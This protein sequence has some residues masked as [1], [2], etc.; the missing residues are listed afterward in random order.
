MNDLRPIEEEELCYHN[1]D[2]VVT[3]DQFDQN[4]AAPYTFK[5]D[6]HENLIK[7]LE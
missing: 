1:H 2:S 7:N 4:I 5:Q 3:N 6:Y